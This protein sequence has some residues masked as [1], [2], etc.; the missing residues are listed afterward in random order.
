LEKRA[1]GTSDVIVSRLC[2]GTLTISPLQ[3][4]MSPQEGGR[5]LIHALHKGILFFD[6]AEIYGTYP[7]LRCMLEEYPSAVIATKCYA[8]DAK[9]AEES[10]VKAV[11]GLGRDYVDIFLLHEQ[12]SVHTI[13]GHWEAL[14]YFIK[15]KQEGS[16][17]AVGISTHTVDAARAALKY[18]EIQVVHP[19]INLRGVGIQGGTRGDMEQAIEALSGAGRGVYAM[20]ALG[21]GHLIPERRSA[22]A[23]ALGLKGVQSVAVGMQSE[24]EIDYN[25][26]LFEGLEPSD[27][28]EAAVGSVERRLVVHDWCRGCGRCAETCRAGALAIVEGRAVPDNVKC[29]LCGYCAA[30]C[31]E[32]CIKV[33]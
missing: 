15:R 18:L 4:N 32:F 25:V 31:P 24:A 5:L 26:A 14:E 6:T 19:L 10:F 3:R 23:Y 16:I 7:H 9:T 11:R 1:L 13:R 12:E 29:T 20:K 17:G 27:E 22:I 8:Y 33:L 28:L 2:F 21:G 30:V